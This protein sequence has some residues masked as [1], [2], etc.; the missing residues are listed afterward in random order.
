MVELGHILHVF[1]ELLLKCLNFPLD[2]E[3]LLHQHG[4]RLHI[5][6]N[7]HKPQ[8]TNLLSD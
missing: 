1:D 7:L 8:L 3:I 2:I 6:Q 5:P 4:K